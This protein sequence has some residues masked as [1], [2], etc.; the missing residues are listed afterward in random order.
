MA[1]VLFVPGGKQRLHDFFSAVSRKRNHI[2]STGQ[3]MNNLSFSKMV[4]ASFEVF[5]FFIRFKMQRAGNIYHLG[6]RKASHTGRRWT[7]VTK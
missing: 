6:E 5:D 3:V 4:T 1:K 7:I 2:H